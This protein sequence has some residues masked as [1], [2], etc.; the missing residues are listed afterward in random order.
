MSNM[1]VDFL[2][3]AAVD[4]RRVNV[5]LADDSAANLLVLG[6]VLGALDEE[7]VT[8]SSGEAA[9]AF[10]RQQDFA[11]ILL[12]LDVPGMDGLA[13]ARLIRD[14]PRAQ[15][16]PIVVVT[17]IDGSNAVAAAEA[18]G[19]VDFLA[20]PAMPEIIRAKV[21][22]FV[23]LCRSKEQLRAERAFLRAVLE[24]VEDAIIATDATGA[25]TL[26]N[27]AGRALFDEVGVSRPSE[28]F[29][30][31]V[32][33]PLQRALRGEQVCRTEVRLGA[34]THR[35]I[36]DAS[37]GPLQDAN[38]EVMGAVISLHDITAVR[39]VQSAQDEVVLQTGR[40]EQAEALTGQL[41]DSQEGLR[42]LAAELSEAD[43]RKTEFLATLAHELR[44][45]LAPL[46]NG[47]EL[48]RMAEDRPELRARTRDMM[49]RQI[50]QLVRLVDDLLEV[51]RITS[52]K[53]Q[54]QR[55]VVEL[56]RI[57]RDSMESCTP[58][59]QKHGHRF[60]AD[61]PQEAIYLDGD[62]ARLCQVFC[63][64]LNNA[65]KYTPQGGEVKLLAR[66]E[67]HTV[68][69]EVKDTGVGIPAKALPQVFDMFTQVERS[70]S[71]A[72]GGLGIGLALV[73]SLVEMHGGRVAAFSPG[74]G[75][76]ST[77]RV[78][79]PTAHQAVQGAEV[80]APIRTALNYR[81]LVVDDNVDAADSLAAVLE[82]RGHSVAVAHDGQE[83]LDKAGAFKPQVVF[84]DI[85]MPRM[86][87]YEVARAL[88][89]TSFGAGAVLVALTGWGAERDRE[90][91]LE[92]GFDH[93]LTK[94]GSTQAISLLV[95]GF[96][97]DLRRRMESS[98]AAPALAPMAP[99]D[100]T[101]RHTPTIGG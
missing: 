25:P 37:S 45:P 7:L 23:D 32:A 75:C 78:V 21:S 20:R 27:R 54:L 61:L 14:I 38:G 17:N 68:T 11:V 33:S 90:R 73:R 3:A 80:I 43:R 94:P 39:G 96:D 6:A 10:A 18:M 51:A 92:A 87:G 47:V 44:N 12:N 72:D 60:H 41:R 40:R 8:A 85:G 82:M 65:A 2:N 26:V 13:A 28:L 62:P 19:G 76:G 81:I 30:A 1:S 49:D 89:N 79:L 71:R 70:I 56:S 46:A 91:T 35:R 93:H 42:R 5:L 59:L 97:D 86:N 98:A 95:D 53:V 57:L 99:F 31:S 52:G 34:G 50:K 16:T 84:L 100:A 67:G 63:N 15:S 4:K 69:I 83:A 58:A 48:L 74:A 55:E 29:P 22:V 88:R 9:I 101:A 24:R 66:R 77:F 36:M 64:L